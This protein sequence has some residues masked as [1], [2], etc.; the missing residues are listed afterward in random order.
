MAPLPDAPGEAVGAVLNAQWRLVSLIGEGGLAAVYEA[1]GLDPLRVVFLLLL[2]NGTLDSYEGDWRE[3]IQ[4]EE[5]YDEVLAPIVD[6]PEVD[7]ATIDSIIESGLTYLAE[8]DEE[9]TATARRR[10]L[11]A[12]ARAKQGPVP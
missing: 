11:L 8:R 3:A 6:R 4:R 12:R 7:G 9:S 5:F 10:E 1:E 2:Y